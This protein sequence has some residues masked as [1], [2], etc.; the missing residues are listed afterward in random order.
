MFPLDVL[1]E[2]NFVTYLKTQLMKENFLK[3]F[4]PLVPKYLL[5]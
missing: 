3:L 4:I 5:T 1:K 2:S